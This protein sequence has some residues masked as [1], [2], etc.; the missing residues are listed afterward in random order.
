MP[1][2]MIIK[3]LLLIQNA[4]QKCQKL[5]IQRKQVE[6]IMKQHHGSHPTIN[7]IAMD[8]RQKKNFSQTSEQFHLFQIVVAIERVLNRIFVQLYTT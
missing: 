3:A 2:W 6:Q 7:F 8:Y 1:T 4:S 5:F